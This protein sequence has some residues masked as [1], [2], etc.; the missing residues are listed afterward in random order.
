[1]KIII[2]FIFFIELLVSAQTS[3]ETDYTGIWK[4]DCS[5]YYGVQI[6]PAE[7]QLYS[8][9]FCGLNGC[10]EPGKWTPNTPIEGDPKYK[11]VSATELGIKRTDGGGYFFYK[12]CTSDP[13]WIVAETQSIEPRKV[14]DCSFATTSKEQGVII[15]WVTGVREFT[16]FGRGIETQTIRVE[17][18]RPI[19]VLKDSG[20]KETLGATI[21]KGQ[22]FWRVLSPASSPL[23]LTSVGSFFDH[24]VDR[25]AYYG[26][27]DKAN[28][29]RWTLLSSKPLP[30]KREW[31]QA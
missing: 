21:H 20:L 9:S 17:S 10:F 27:L 3:G 11:V 18:F 29:P 8:V 23:K 12:K 16:Q 2:A 22:S 4:T 25:C 31:G 7:N 14:P 19:A 24:L 5:N 13:T 30:G 26:T 6:K 1:M 28:L 15:A